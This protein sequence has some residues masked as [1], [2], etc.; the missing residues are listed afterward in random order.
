MLASHSPHGAV[1]FV[2][3]LFTRCMPDVEITNLSGLI[4]LLED[5]DDVMADKGF[6]IKS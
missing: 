2:S 4:D 3:T 6:T 1:T 5:G